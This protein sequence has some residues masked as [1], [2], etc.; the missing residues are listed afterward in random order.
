MVWY[1]LLDLP[2]RLHL[3]KLTA[4]CGDHGQNA[5]Q[6]RPAIAQQPVRMRLGKVCR[7]TA[8][9]WNL[10]QDLAET[11]RKSSSLAWSLHVLT[12]LQK[13]FLR[14][15]HIA[16]SSGSEFF[17]F[18]SLSSVVLPWPREKWPAIWWK[19]TCPTAPPWDGFNLP[20][21]ALQATINALAGGPSDGGWCSGCPVDWKV[22]MIYIDLL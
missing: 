15:W 11:L 14:I 16:G 21:N 20:W 8:G 17:V 6:P 5:C 12:F 2:D 22:Y 1:G 10:Y 13:P 19:T 9:R 4:G 7:Q 3:V 18:H